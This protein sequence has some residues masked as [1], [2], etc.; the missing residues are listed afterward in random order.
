[1]LV[2]TIL[3]SFMSPMPFRAAGRY[4]QRLQTQVTEY[5]LSVESDISIHAIGRKHND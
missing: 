2:I 5:N 4:E 3:H 1:M